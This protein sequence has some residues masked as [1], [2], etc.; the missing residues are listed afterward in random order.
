MLLHNILAVLYPPKFGLFLTLLNVF[1]VCYCYKTF[2]NNKSV[3]L[4]PYN[5]LVHAMLI[6]KLHDVFFNGKC[7]EMFKIS[8]Y[9]LFKRSTL[10]TI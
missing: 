1:L 3:F 9:T 2:N 10:E 8:G 6:P 4:Q 7:T 5:F